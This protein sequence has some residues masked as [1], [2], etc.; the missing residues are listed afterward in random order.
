MHFKLHILKKRLIGAI[1]RLSD[2]AIFIGIIL[3]GGLGSS[4]YMVSAGSALTTRSVGPWI[5]WTAAGRTDADPY[6]QAHFAR[7][8]S[9]VLST[10]LAATYLA[11]TDDDGLRL[12]SSCDYRIEGRELEASWWSLTVFDDSGALIPNPSER[13]AFTSETVALTPEGEFVVT[14]ARDARAGNWLPTGGAGRLTLAMTIL[15]GATSIVA[16][17]DSELALPSISRVACR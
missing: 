11:A 6:T 1:D 5:T 12:H 4:W 17:S 9:L 7:T 3:I 2:W 8:G 15:E 10:E 16:G 13:H 14:L